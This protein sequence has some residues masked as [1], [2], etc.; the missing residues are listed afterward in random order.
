M[1]QT[2]KLP[3][4][5]KSIAG[6]HWPSDKPTHV[7][8]LIHG[9]G[10]H[11]GRYERMACRFNKRQIA[12]I[13]IDLR[14]HGLSV[15]KRGHTAPRQEILKDIDYLIKYTMELYKD[16]PIVMYGHSMGGNITLDYRI[17]GNLSYV[18][19]AYI[20]SAPWVQLYKPFPTPIV[21]IVKA[22]SKFSPEMQFSSSVDEAIL[23]NPISVGKYKSDPLVHDKITALC[24]T[25]CLS[26]GKELFEGTLEGNG[27]GRCKPLL[28]MHGD[29][30][31]ICAVSGSRAVAL[32]EGKNCTY[33]EWP[34][35]YHEIHNGGTDSAGDE[36]IQRAIDFIKSIS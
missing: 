6:Y 34:G 14:G 20:A 24:A 35:L 18:P 1:Y 30:D 33:V 17:R 23:G 5:V 25:D 26:V 32:N 21:G 12:V 22:L 27:G 11:A 29:S 4:D 7:V 10:E 8:C 13:A 9:I 16:V 36:V 2:F 3:S 15:G 19:S 28:L 31:K